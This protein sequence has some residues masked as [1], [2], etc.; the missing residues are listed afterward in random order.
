MIL[1]LTLV[2][3]VYAIALSRSRGDNTDG[4]FVPAHPNRSG[5]VTRLS[6]PEILSGYYLGYYILLKTSFGT[7]APKWL[8]QHQSYENPD[9]RKMGF[10]CYENKEGHVSKQ[11]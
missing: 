10:C 8:D 2:I 7:G 1:L 5:E 11:P 3:Q 4:K 9:S 6:N